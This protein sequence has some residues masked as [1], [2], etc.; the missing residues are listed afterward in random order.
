MYKW[1]LSWLFKLIDQVCEKSEKNNS[2]S[3]IEKVL[4]IKKI[5]LE[6]LFDKICPSLK[7][8][9]RLLFSL[10]LCAGIM[11]DRG[12]LEKEGYFI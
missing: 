9:H 4:E 8:I 1:P 2:I 5:Y 3:L 7:S 12:E 11:I 10:F 6:I